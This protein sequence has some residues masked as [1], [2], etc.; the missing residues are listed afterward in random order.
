MAKEE[1]EF[2]Y[3]EIVATIWDHWTLEKQQAIL[4]YSIKVSLAKRSATIY[5]HSC[6]WT[7]CE[8][9]DLV[10]QV[11]VISVHTADRQHISYCILE[12]NTLFHIMSD[13]SRLYY[14]IES[15]ESK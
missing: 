12:I 11:P 9:L 8:G 4:K 5:S 7:S 6:V 2:K 1:E 10:Q 14:A 13:S 3:Q 15:I